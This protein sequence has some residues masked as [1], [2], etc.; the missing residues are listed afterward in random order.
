[1]DPKD[2]DLM[3][4]TPVPPPSADVAPSATGLVDGDADDLREAP[5]SPDDG[6]G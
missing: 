4:A 2:D 6:E 5:A 3:D 1:M